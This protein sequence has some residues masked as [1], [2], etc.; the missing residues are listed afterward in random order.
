ME[1]FEENSM[2]GPVIYQDHAFQRELIR[3]GT[4][5]QIID[6]LC[7]N[8]PNGAYKDSDCEI[9]GM[10]ATTLDQARAIMRQQ[11][12]PISTVI[13]RIA[14]EAANSANMAEIDR[15]VSTQKYRHIVAWGKW[16]GFT[17]VAVLQIV[18]EAEADNAPPDAIQKID[19]RWLRL[20]DIANETNRRRVEELA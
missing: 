3:T 14:D 13:P 19:G 16:L 4:R 2:N 9:E 7:W 18:R 12:D 1:T 5:E 8:D 11:I 15:L 10:N 6:W 17:P 20:E